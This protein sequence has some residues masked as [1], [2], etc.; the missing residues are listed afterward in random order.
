M[1]IETWMEEFYPVDAGETQDPIRHSLQKW[2]GLRPDRLR[3]HG[4]VHERGTG[5][6]YSGDKQVFFVYSETCAL[7][8]KHMYCED[9][10]LFKVLGGAC[11]NGDY[12]PYMVF[13]S[14]GDPEP[15]IKALKEAK[16]QEGSK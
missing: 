6:L 9:C 12:S 10:P 3:E 5:V 8:R 4:L 11:D 13:K 15:M 7:C 16:D 14:T 1:S 2:R